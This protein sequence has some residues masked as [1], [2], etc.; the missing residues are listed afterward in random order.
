MLGKNDWRADEEG[1]QQQ[2]HSLTRVMRVEMLDD[3]DVVRS[4][5]SSSL[6]MTL[7]NGRMC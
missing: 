7:G 6:W 3:D 1:Q 2:Q 5:R 4:Q